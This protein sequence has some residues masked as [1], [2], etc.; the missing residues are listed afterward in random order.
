MIDITTESLIPIGK[1]PAEIERLTGERPHRGTVE[2]WR[3]RGCHGVKL[4]TLKVGA[5]RYV[6]LGSLQRFF[7]AVTAAV[8]GDPATVPYKTPIQKQRSIKRANAELDR[9]G[10]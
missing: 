9:A 5:R 1:A 10:I 7:L 4:E 3:M 6:S 2:R 8:D